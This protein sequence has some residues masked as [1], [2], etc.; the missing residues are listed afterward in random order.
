MPE[1]LLQILQVEY[2]CD[3]EHPPSAKYAVA[4]EDVLMRM[5]AVWEIAECLHSDDATRNRVAFT[6]FSTM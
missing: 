1:E 5:K 3:L 4:A 2:R 6:R